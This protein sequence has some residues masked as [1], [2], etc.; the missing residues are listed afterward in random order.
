MF[1]IEEDSSLNEETLL[2]SGFCFTG[3][4]NTTSYNNS[5]FSI[6]AIVIKQ[7]VAYLYAVF[8]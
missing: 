2:V 1:I 8:I 5:K 4:A 3:L 7:Q 6:G